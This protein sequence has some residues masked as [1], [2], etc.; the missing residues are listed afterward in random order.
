[1]SSGDG[2]AGGTFSYT[3]TARAATGRAHCARIETPHGCI[4]TPNFIF[5]ATHGAIKSAT[6]AQMKDV[7]A[8][9]VLGNTYHLWL[10]PGYELVA[11]HGGLHRFVGWDGPMLTDSGGFQI[12]S[13][14]YGRVVDEIKGKAH[15]S[16]FQKSL[17]RVTEDGA[18]FRSHI[19]GSQRFLTP[20][21][22]IEIQQGLGA[23][24][25]LTL[26][27]CA[28]TH[29]SKNE[30]AASMH[31]S[32]RWETRSLNYFQSHFDDRQRLYGIVQGGEFE[33]LRHE[34]IDFI[35]ENPFFGQAIG[36]S[37]GVDKQQMY[38]LV[39]CVMKGLR[40]R[41][42]HLLGIGGLRDILEGVNA[43]IDTFDCV[44][45]TRIARHACALVAKPEAEYAKEHLNLKN[46]RYRED[47]NPI[48]A[49]CDCYTCKNFTR[50]YLHHLFKAREGTGGLLLTIH[51]ARFTV[52]WMQSIREAIKG[53]YWEAFYREHACR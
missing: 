3:I 19:D 47:M 18:L 13:L 42:T 36:G 17:L 28:P 8:Q 44:H 6:M 41:P 16:D 53:G 2:T 5:C 27:E 25:I 15:R 7:G 37:L 31:R 43:G 45:P 32:H 10:Q 1:M 24:L 39:D 21:K 20:E 49:E 12:F 40:E 9:I 11:K 23:D 30:T 14:A 34:S 22:S 38:A 33:D 29:F 4:E 51:N 48:D 50:A 35:N 26:D 46:A 52:R